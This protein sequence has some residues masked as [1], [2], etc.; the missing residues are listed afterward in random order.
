MFAKVTRE[1]KPVI[2]PRDFTWNV[3]LLIKMP[4]TSR[5]RRLSYIIIVF[6]FPVLTGF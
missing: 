6:V 2:A 4:C 1:T 5:A 3:K